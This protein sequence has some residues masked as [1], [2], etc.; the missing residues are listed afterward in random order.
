MEQ[1]IHLCRCKNF[2]SGAEW[3]AAHDRLDARTD[4]RNRSVSVLLVLALVV[5]AQSVGAKGDRERLANDPGV[6]A[7]IAVFKVG[8][9][10]MRNPGLRG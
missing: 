10:W 5:S 2:V 9:Q 4:M 6:Y 3:K 1:F 8:D 7:T